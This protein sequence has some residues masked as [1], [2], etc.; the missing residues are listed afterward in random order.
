MRK[1]IKTLFIVVL[2]T[3]VALWGSQQLRFFQRLSMVFGQPA[4]AANGPSNEGLQ[5]RGQGGYRGGAGQES[6]KGIVR[7][8]NGF[9]G[10][11]RGQGGHARTA[12]LEG[13]I[14]V[15]AYLSIFAFFV[16]LAYYGEQSIR[17][18][19]NRPKACVTSS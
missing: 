1:Q 17:K 12:S 14:N 11:G 16:M 13:W 9:G 19:G 2:I 7:G 6:R 3:G 5:R 15:L 8:G 10:R 4:F 18:L